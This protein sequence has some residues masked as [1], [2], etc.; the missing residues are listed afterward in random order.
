MLHHVQRHAAAIYLPAAIV[1]CCLLLCACSALPPKPAAPIEKG[2]PSPWRPG[3]P[4]PLFAPLTNEC[5]A[6]PNNR[7]STSPL[8]L[9]GVRYGLNVFMFDTDTERVLTLTNIA[10][11]GWVRQQIHW[12][13]IEGKRGQYIW[14]PLDQIVSAARSHDLNIMLSVVRSPAWATNAGDS[15]LPDDTA[16]FGTFLRQMSTR[17]RGRVS[18]YEI[19]NEPNLA[20]ENGGTPGAPADYLATLQA[21]YPAVKAGDPCAVVL[22]APL[23]ATNDPEPQKAVEDIPF[24]EE[25]Y[26]LD[27]GAFLHV[28]DAVA[29]HPGA[30]MH[31]PMATWPDD[32]PETSHHYFRHVERV[33]EVM[34]RHNDPRQV[35]ITEVG[36]TVETAEGAPPPVSQEQQA[37]YLVDTLWFVR[38]RYPW[39]AGVF[40]WNLNFNVIAPPGDEKTTYSILNRD[41]ST[42]PSFIALQHNIPALR[43]IEHPPLMSDDADSYT[44]QWNFPARGAVQYAPILAEDGTIYTVSTPGTVY[45]ITTTGL[46]DWSYHANGIISGAPARTPDG[47]LYLGHSGS[48]FVALDPDGTVAWEV[49]LRS[50]MRGSPLSSKGRIYFVTDIGEVLAF[51]LP[52]DVSS[53]VEDNSDDVLLQ[54]GDDYVRLWTHDFE[55]ETTTPALSSDGMLLLGVASGDVVK[56]GTDGRIRWRTP[57]GD[58]VWAAPTPDSSG[59]AYIVTVSGRVV[60]LDTHGDVRWWRALGAPVVASPLVGYDKSIYIAD[61]NRLLWALD[62]DN[63]KERWH[64]QTGSDMRATPMQHA[65]G[66]LFVGTEDERLLAISADGHIQWQAYLRGAVRATP[67]LAADQTLYV[68]TMAGR[69]YAFAPSVAAVRF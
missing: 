19:W 18:V 36:W 29:V 16:A 13:D 15:G 62:A 37:T 45:A 55:M 20:H 41:W 25:L 21:A 63:G 53:L 67:V 52:D 24:Y 58:G 68:G 5:L 3:T 17:Y 34:L 10:G 38:Q 12:R 2:I 27:N 54:E 28:A 61:R 22:A 4:E 69:L 11:F 1:C 47:M 66:T 48:Q 64:V 60:A 51:A 65:D 14:R 59:G 46:L 56:M 9:D 23:A 40:V 26:T 44:F 32:V 31:P 42:R 43:D 35:W 39:I 7:S 33:H 57:V 30:G 49:R 8:H 50:P 6:T